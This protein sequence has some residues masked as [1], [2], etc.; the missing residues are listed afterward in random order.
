MGVFKQLHA[1]CT[2]SV[3]FPLQ[4]TVYC[5]YDFVQA[6]LFLFAFLSVGLKFHLL[7]MVTCTK[8]YKFYLQSK[9][10]HAKLLYK[11]K[12]LRE[13]RVILKLS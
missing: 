13:M 10:V 1:I 2:F 5:M 6:V 3:P 4:H 7:M 11:L 12:V 9:Y 8:L